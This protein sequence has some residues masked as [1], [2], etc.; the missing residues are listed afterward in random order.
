MSQ[1]R[2]VLRSNGAIEHCFD[3]KHEKSIKNEKNMMIFAKGSWHLIKV[4]E[5][6]ILDIEKGAWF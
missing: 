6:W 2:D 5:K 4:S 1:S 3:E